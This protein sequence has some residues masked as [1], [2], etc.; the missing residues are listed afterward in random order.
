MTVLRARPP[1]LLL[2][3][4][5]AGLAGYGDYLLSSGF[6][7]VEAHSG[8]QAVERAAALLPDLI[9]LDFGLDGETV[10]QLREH[11]RTGHIPIIALTELDTLH[12]S[13]DA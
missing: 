11:S 5:E 3:V 13:R 4:Y 9:V 8:A 7:V 10:A 1:P 12:G 2:M 6:R